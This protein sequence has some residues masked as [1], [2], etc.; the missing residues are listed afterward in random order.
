[1]RESQSSLPESGPVVLDAM[2]RPRLRDA[3][4]ASLFGWGGTSW[5]S[6]RR[7]RIVRMVL[8]ISG[9]FLG[10]C[11]VWFESMLPPGTLRWQEFG[12]LAIAGLALAALYFVYDVVVSLEMLEKRAVQADLDLARQIQK[13]MLPDQLPRL[14]GWEF[15]AYHE[16]ARSIGGDAYD[17]RELDDG[18]L[19]LTV[20][21]VAGKGA[22]AALLSTGVLARLRALARTG[23]DVDELTVRLSAALVEETDPEHFAT[24]VVGELDPRSGELVYVNAGNAPPLWL[25]ADGSIE[26][27]EAGGLPVG[28]LPDAEY[29]ETR[30]VLQPGD[31]V[32]IAT[33]GLFDADEFGGVLVSE[34][35]L[36]QRL[37]D[38][39]DRPLA[40]VVDA[41]VREVHARSGANRFDD[42]TLLAF[43][44]HRAQR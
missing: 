41:L 32:L 44:R 14:D 16:S 1:M 11:L 13:R 30:I 29:E 17:V 8:P 43:G 27:L 20:T 26:L 6:R 28:M 42:L 31:R 23:M 25:R 33:D 15:A 38:T 18:R 3:V 24:L 21:D 7:Q 40:E 34:E 36:R 2:N 39:R 37:L 12:V 35:E 22:A 5:M 4:R 19:L 10:V 9:F